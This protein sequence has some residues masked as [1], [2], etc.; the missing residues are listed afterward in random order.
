MT[1]VNQAAEGDKKYIVSLGATNFCAYAKNKDR[2]IEL[3]AETLKR[4]WYFDAL[5]VE[6]MAQSVNKTVE[7]FI[8]DADLQPCPKYKIYLP[9]LKIKEMPV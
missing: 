7:E 3:V 5:E 8:A 9:K 1:V 4:D 6:L 2:A